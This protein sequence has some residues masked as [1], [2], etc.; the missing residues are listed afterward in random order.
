MFGSGGSD[1]SADSGAQQFMD[2]LTI[3][4]ASDLAVDLNIK[5]GGA[6]QPAATPAPTPTE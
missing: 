4:A 1:L 6:A 3:K 5:Q 2:I